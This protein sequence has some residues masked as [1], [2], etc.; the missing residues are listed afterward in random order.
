M[1]RSDTPSSQ[2]MQ[3]SRSG[4]S[5]LSLSPRLLAA[6][7]A[8]RGE[9]LAEEL[10]IFL[11]GRFLGALLTIRS[12]GG[13]PRATGAAGKAELWVSLDCAAVA[14]PISFLRASAALGLCLAVAH[15]PGN[16]PSSVPL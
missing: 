15:T 16:G 12:L 11:A 4:V 3:L 7:G 5:T 9:A 8:V 2:P 14:P 13:S 1:S 6:P 10:E